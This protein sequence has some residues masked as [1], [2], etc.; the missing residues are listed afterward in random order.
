MSV[1]LALNNV[2]LANLVK[3][4]VIMGA[5]HGSYGVGGVLGPI[6][7][8]AMVSKGSPWQRYYFITLGIRLVSLVF[9]GW[10]FWG[11]EKEAPARLREALETTASRRAVAEGGDPSKVKLLKRALKDRVTLMGALFIFSYQGAEVSIS[12]WVI[13]YL[14]EY[15]N[16]DPAHVGYV[17]AGFWVSRQLHR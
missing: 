4:T 9:V 3:G 15:R 16:G 2:F 7:A 1:D 17:T 11:Y 12:G 8:T 10:A 14:I 6:I 5:A 13:T